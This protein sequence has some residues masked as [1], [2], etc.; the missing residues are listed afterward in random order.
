MV[1]SPSVFSWHESLLPIILHPAGR[2]FTHLKVPV[3][4]SWSYS[5]PNVRSHSFTWGVRNACRYMGVRGHLSVSF[6]SLSYPPH[7]HS[8]LSVLS[9]TL[10]T[11]TRYQTLEVDD[12]QAYYRRWHS[13]PPS[14]LTSEA[15]DKLRTYWD[16]SVW[17]YGTLCHH[18]DNHIWEAWY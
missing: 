7:T 6:P 1:P 5:M 2:S 4:T 13:T 18:V 12:S 11:I 15:S 9:P 14:A 16:R 10:C 3:L 8:C 17:H